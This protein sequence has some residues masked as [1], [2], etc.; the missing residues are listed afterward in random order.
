[1]IAMW[2]VS[3]QKEKRYV[4]RCHIYVIL[5]GW[6]D[7]EFVLPDKFDNWGQAVKAVMDARMTNVSPYV[8]DPAIWKVFETLA[9]ELVP[10]ING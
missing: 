7:S 5:I 6:L 4:H 3:T 8:V 2:R 9:F 10:R 1:M